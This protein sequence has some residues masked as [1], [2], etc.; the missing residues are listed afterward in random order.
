MRTLVLIALMS[1]LVTPGFAQTAAP[2]PVPA[3]PPA[4]V[5]APSPGPGAARAPNASRDA[6][7]TEIDAKSLTGP[8]RQ[9]AMRTCMRGRVEACRKEAATQGVPARSAERREFVQRCVRQ[10][11]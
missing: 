11:S 7:R 5:P 2:T 3:S 6:C 1:I 4:S 10:H 9:E 8:E